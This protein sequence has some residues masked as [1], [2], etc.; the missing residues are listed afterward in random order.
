MAEDFKSCGTCFFESVEADKEPCK[1]C[2]SYVKW[3]SKDTYKEE[4]VNNPAHYTFGQIEVVDAILDWKLNFPLGNVIKYVAR[5]DH[6]GNA[7]EDLKK[8]RKY[9]DIEIK[10]RESDV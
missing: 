10:H 8:A 4:A 2:Y 9:L 5:A 7:I 1:S 6:K 3:L